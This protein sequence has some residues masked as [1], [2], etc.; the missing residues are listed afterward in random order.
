M[1]RCADQAAIHQGICRLQV[2]HSFIAH[3]LLWDAQAE[4]DVSWLQPAQER[5]GARLTT[6]QQQEGQQAACLQAGIKGNRLRRHITV[7]HQG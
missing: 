4:T 6:A 1:L 7:T 2:P 3:A 5:D